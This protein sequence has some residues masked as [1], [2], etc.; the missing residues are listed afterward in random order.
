MLPH[1]PDKVTRLYTCRDSVVDYSAR[2]Y[3]PQ[4]HRYGM[5][6][7]NASPSAFSLSAV[8]VEG[9]CGINGSSR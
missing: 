8:L 3:P 5:D 6:V 1:V 4:I 7:R 2:R 9:T